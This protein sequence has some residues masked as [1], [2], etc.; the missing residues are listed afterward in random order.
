[1]LHFEQQHDAEVRGILRRLVA[2]NEAD[3]LHSETL[4]LAQVTRH[5]A[6]HPQVAGMTRTERSGNTTRPSETALIVRCMRS[7]HSPM[8]S[9]EWTSAERRIRISTVNS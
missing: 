3:Q 2:W 7:M 8:G 1:M 9:K 4:G 6:H 5:V